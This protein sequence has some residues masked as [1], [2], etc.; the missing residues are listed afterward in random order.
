[1]FW[2][3]RDTIAKMG[4]C[5]EQHLLAILRSRMNINKNSAKLV[6]EMEK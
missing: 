1:M 3:E 4:V 6:I 5:R 2:V